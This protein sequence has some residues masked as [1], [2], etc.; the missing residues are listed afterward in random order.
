M[1][2][3]SIDS[4]KFDCGIFIDLRN[5]FDTVNHEILLNKL[6][7]YG[8]RDTML[9]WFLSY[10][11]DR[12]QYVSFNGQSSELLKCSVLGPLLFLLYINDLP[13]ISKNLNF[14]LF[15]DDTNIYYESNSLTDLEKTVNNEL[16]KL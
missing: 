6:E 7:H 4:G 9:K 8:V 2:K 12:K 10:L 11:S 3:E 15:A 13:N 5:A 16:D 1:I 14:Y